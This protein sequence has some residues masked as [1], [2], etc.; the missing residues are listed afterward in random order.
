[1]FL[2]VPVVPFVSNVV[3]LVQSPLVSSFFLSMA[4]QV[5]LN[6]G[7]EKLIDDGEG[8]D[9]FIDNHVIFQGGVG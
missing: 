1:M 3:S 2:V 9:K 4:V 7:E 8:E 6:V 5:K